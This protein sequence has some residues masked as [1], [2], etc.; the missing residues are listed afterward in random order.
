MIQWK[1]DS[2]E[3]V[4]LTTTDCGMIPTCPNCESTVIVELEATNGSAATTELIDAVKGDYGKIGQDGFYEDEMRLQPLSKA[5]INALIK[6][7]S[8]AN[9]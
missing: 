5:V 9:V 2:C 7:C 8:R 3:E 1:C 6:V 4:F